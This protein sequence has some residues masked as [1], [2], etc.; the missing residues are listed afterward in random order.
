MDN[1]A[2]VNY[3]NGLK[4]KPSDPAQAATR[5]RQ[6]F[7]DA[8]ADLIDLLRLLLHFDP[9][10]RLSAVE[11][12]QHP[13][14]HMY[15]SAPSDAELPLPQVRTY[16]YRPL[17]TVTQHYIPLHIVTY[18]YTTLHI[19]TCH[20]RRFR[21][22]WRAPLAPPSSCAGPSGRKCCAFTR[23]W[24]WSVAT[25]RQSA[26]HAACRRASR[27]WSASAECAVAACPC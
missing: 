2:A 13:Y 1:A 7:P 20:C 4:L 24:L 18:R 26:G 21:T 19:V 22:T 27:R 11:A 5:L 3:I 10:K 6:L 16:R 8:S 25:A 14:M 12:L 23:K 17:H 15:R 9:K